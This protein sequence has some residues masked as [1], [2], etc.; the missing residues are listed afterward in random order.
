MRYRKKQAT[1][2]KRMMAQESAT[3]SNARGS[4]NCI[5]QHLS[6][7]SL[8]KKLTQTKSKHREYHCMLSKLKKKSASIF[9]LMERLFKNRKRNSG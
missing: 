8:L 6:K 3:G 7:H 9:R 1:E 4:Q 2:K 5:L